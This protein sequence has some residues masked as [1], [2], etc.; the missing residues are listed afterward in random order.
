MDVGAGSLSRDREVLLDVLAEVLLSPVFPEEE[1]E[2][3]RMRLAGVV[4]EQQD[5]TSV[6][7]YETAARRMYPREHPFYRRT[8]EERIAAIESL[9]REELVRFYEERY[10]A[11]AMLLVA[12]AT[13]DSDEVLDGLER[14]SAH[15]GAATR[16][17]ST[18]GSGSARPGLGDRADADTAGP[19]RLAHTGDLE[20]GAPTTVRASSRTPR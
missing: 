3:E 7:A 10:G 19:S 1:L 18:A 20:G 17:S 6:R 4:R 15:V 12:W 2:K 14:R 5:Q 13:C 9:K 11:G 8:A 16:S